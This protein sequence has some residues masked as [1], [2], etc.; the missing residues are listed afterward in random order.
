VYEEQTSSL[1]SYF[2][3][4]G[5]FHSVLGVGSISDIQSKI[6]LI[7]GTGDIGDHS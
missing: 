5:L 6:C 3:K 7:I 1:K 2:K 4:L